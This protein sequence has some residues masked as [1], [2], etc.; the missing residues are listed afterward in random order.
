MISYVIYYGRRYAT[1]K[2]CIH[3]LCNR[4][5][6][7][8]VSQYENISALPF[9]PLRS[10]RHA[11]NRELSTRAFEC[12]ASSSR[13]PGLPATARLYPQ[14]PLRAATV[15][16]SLNF[17]PSKLSLHTLTNCDLFQIF[18]EILHFSEQVKL[19]FG[20]VHKCVTNVLIL[21]SKCLFV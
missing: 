13:R 6:T 7:A 20:A 18:K 19:A 17:L 15:S 11:I 2:K 21:F 9:C 12:E 3:N 14:D 16:T 5:S 1:S 8:R 10:L 4:N